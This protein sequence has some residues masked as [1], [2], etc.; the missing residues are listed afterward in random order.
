VTWEK[1]QNL[2]SDWWGDCRFAYQEEVKQETYAQFMGLTQTHF[3]GKMGYDVVG[4]SIVDIGGG[5]A[6]ILLKAVHLKAGKVIDPIRFPDWVEKR[7]NHMNIERM[8]C[9][10]EDIPVAMPHAWDEAWVYNCLQ[11]VKSPEAVLE[12]AKLLSKTVRIFEWISS[13][14]DES[15]PH[16][17]SKDRLDK[18]LGCDGKTL[19]LSHD[20]YRGCQGLAYFAVAPVKGA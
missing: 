12:N 5:P 14:V 1:A 4:R 10:G 2:E 17:L 18:A 11:H 16:S 8:Y 20:V 3:A 13:H 19:F 15:H 9:A 6:S 7:Y